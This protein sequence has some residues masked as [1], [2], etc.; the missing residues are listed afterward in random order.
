[1][2][3]TIKVLVAKEYN[4][5]NKA[6]LIIDDEP[7]VIANPNRMN[8]IINYLS[9]GFGEVNDGKIKKKLD[10]L[11]D[12]ILTKKEQKKLPPLPLTGSHVKGTQN[13]C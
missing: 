13:I 8:K 5:R 6:L 9:Y 12:D 3:Y 2:R 11:R 4:G 10:E 7:I 1:M